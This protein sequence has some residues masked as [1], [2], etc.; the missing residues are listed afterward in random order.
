M[1]LAELERL[2]AAVADRRDVWIVDSYYTDE[3]KNALL[4]ACDCYV[5]LH[6]SEGLGLTMA[7]AMAL[8]KPVVATGYSGNLHFMT[9]ENS[10]M[11]DYVRTPVPPGCDPYPTTASWA[12]PDLDQAAAYLRDVFERPEEAA[13]RARKGQQD[14]LDRHNPETSARAISERV[15]AIRRE[16]RSRVVGLPGASE[17]ATTGSAGRSARAGSAS[18]SSRRCS[19]HWPRPRR[20]A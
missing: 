2:R 5:S 4:G 18:S 17:T 19:P 3:E 1:R 7:E 16:R 11:V 12:E 9:P 10:Y 14:I 6:R 8:G 13:R 15:E 20:C